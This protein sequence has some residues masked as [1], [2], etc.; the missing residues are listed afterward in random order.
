MWG[1]GSAVMP[2]WVGLSNK[3]AAQLVPRQAAW[4]AD[5]SPRGLAGRTCGHVP[6]PLEQHELRH[7]GRA[8]VA[9]AAAAVSQS[10]CSEGGRMQHGG[11]EQRLDPPWHSAAGEGEGVS[12]QRRR[13]LR[14]ASASAAA[15]ATRGRPLPA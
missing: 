13:Q 15:E 8:A 12:G 2:V 9:D 3:P 10:T 4:P 1:Q 6:P 11:R 5:G 7:G 14:G